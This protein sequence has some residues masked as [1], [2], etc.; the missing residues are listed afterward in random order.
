MAIQVIY[1]TRRL[2][3]Q[4]HFLFDLSL[5]ERNLHPSSIT[6]ELPNQFSFESDYGRRTYAGEMPVRSCSR[7][8]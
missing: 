6:F 8:Q 7:L 1:G 3:A 5:A 2:I 4:G